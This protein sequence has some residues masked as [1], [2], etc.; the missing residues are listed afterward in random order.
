M[1]KNWEY[2]RGDIYLADLSPIRGCEQGGI[3]PVVVIQNNIGNFYAPTLIVATVTAK[4]RKKHR[5]PT[6]YFIWNNSAF[7]RP[8]VVVLEQIRTIDKE[9]IMRYLGKLTRKEMEGINAALLISLEL[10]TFSHQ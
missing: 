6:H 3:R 1:K 4:V 2:R 10:N 9:R 7:K 5:Q 8:S